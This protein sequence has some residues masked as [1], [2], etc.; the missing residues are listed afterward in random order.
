MKI[1]PKEINNNYEGRKT[2][3]YLF[4]LFTIMTVARSLIH[5]FTPDGGAQSIATIPLSSY[6]TE[7]ADVVIHIFAEWGLGFLLQSLL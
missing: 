7:A 6:S 4:Y 5:I 2:A 3:L 1:L